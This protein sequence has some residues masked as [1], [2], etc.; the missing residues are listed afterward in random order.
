M[1]RY[2]RSYSVVVSLWLILLHITNS[3]GYHTK[4]TRTTT[5]W[6]LRKSTTFSSDSQQ[7]SP[8]YPSTQLARMKHSLEMSQVQEKPKVSSDSNT[9]PSVIQTS[10]PVK[11]SGSSGAA[12]ELNNIAISI[13]NNDILS[14]INWS[15]LPNERWAI[16]G[17]NGEG[18]HM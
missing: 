5:S 10:S 8:F 7:L 2:C 9:I 4:F 6:K 12:I 1:L 15:I 3:Y 13:G 17:R 18:M 16:V 14:D 11:Y